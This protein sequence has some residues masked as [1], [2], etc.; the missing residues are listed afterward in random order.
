MGHR[1]AATATDRACGSTRNVARKNAG[2][3]SVAGA[4]CCRAVQGR[5]SGTAPEC[6]NCEH[7][8]EDRLGGRRT[9]RL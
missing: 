7:W 3:T 5:A 1:F 9:Q 2:S 8:L 4:C 6:R